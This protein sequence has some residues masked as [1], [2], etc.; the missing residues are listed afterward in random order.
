MYVE[1]ITVSQCVQTENKRHI[2]LEQTGFWREET[3]WAAHDHIDQ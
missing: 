2:V 1:F 3:C